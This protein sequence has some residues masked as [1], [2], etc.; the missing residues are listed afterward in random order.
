[1]NETRTRKDGVVIDLKT[2]LSWK[3][4][5]PWLFLGPLV[6]AA[7]LLCVPPTFAKGPILHDTDPPVPPGKGPI[8]YADSKG[9][10]VYAVA[11]TILWITASRNLSH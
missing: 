1:M 2:G 5:K 11:T 7:V 3:N 9:P 8:V 4:G 10:V 6:L